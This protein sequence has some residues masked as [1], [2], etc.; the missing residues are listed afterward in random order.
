MEVCP[1]TTAGSI[2]AAR[3]SRPVALRTL[4]AY[5]FAFSMAASLGD[6][7]RPRYEYERELARP[8][9]IMIRLAGV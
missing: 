7:V 1:T 4:I 8:G 5:S 3:R 9:N 2:D 6:G